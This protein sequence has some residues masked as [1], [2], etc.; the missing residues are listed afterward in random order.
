MATKTIPP[1][2]ERGAGAL[3]RIA[4]DAAERLEGEFELSATRLD[5]LER[6][7]AEAFTVGVLL[8]DLVSSGSGVD[9]AVLKSAEHVLRA[10]LG[11]FAPIQRAELDVLQL[12][13]AGGDPATVEQ[14]MVDR[15]GRMRYRAGRAIVGLHQGL[16]EAYEHHFDT[17]E[18]S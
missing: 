12:L 16:A 1:D 14:A 13:T 10:T 9:R 6:G 5:D 4:A 2:S 3:V 17:S 18:A 7:F 15:I 8:A 11:A